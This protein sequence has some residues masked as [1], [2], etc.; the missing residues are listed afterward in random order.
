MTTI[1]R[2]LIGT[3]ALVMVLLAFAAY[4]HWSHTP[5]LVIGSKDPA[6]SIERAQPG[7]SP[8]EMGQVRPGHTEMAKFAVAD[9]VTK[10]LSRLFGFR[11]LLNPNEDTV[12]WRLEAPYMNL[13]EDRFFCRITADRGTVQ[14]E[15]VEGSYAPRDAEL[16]QNVRIYLKSLRPGDTTECLIYMNDLSYSSERSLFSTAGPVKVV[17]QQAELV[18]TGMELIYNAASARI[19]LLHIADL[20]SLR[21]RGVA[22]ETAA[23][24]GSSASLTETTKVGETQSL[25]P[26]DGHIA[27][28]DKPADA[29]TAS[30]DGQTS[31]S[32]DRYFCRLDKNIIIWYGR[33]LRVSGA[34]NVDITNILWARKPTTSTPSAQPADDGAATV[35]EQAATPQEAPR[36]PERPAEGLSEQTLTAEADRQFGPPETHDNDETDVRIT[37]DGGMLIR[38]ME[39]YEDETAMTP[40]RQTIQAFGSPVE[41]ARTEITGQTPGQAQTLA[42]C[43]MLRYDTDRSLLTIQRGAWNQDTVLGVGGAGGRLITSGKVTYDRTAQ[44]AIIAGGGRLEM[45]LSTRESSRE[46]KFEMVFDGRMDLFLA[47]ATGPDSPRELLLRR[48]DLTGGMNAELHSDGLARL[49]AENASFT[50]NAD[51]TLARADLSGDVQFASDEGLTVSRQAAIFFDGRNQPARADLHGAVQFSSASGTLTTEQAL[52]RF[53]AAQEGGATLDEIQTQGPATL[54]AEREPET[55]TRK[56]ARFRGRNLHYDVATGHAVAQGPIEFTFHVA[57]PDP[58]DPK[59]EPVPVVITATD[60]AEFDRDKNEFIFFGSVVGLHEVAQADYVQKSSFYGK[61]LIVRLAKATDSAASQAGS[62]IHSITLVGGNVKIESIRSR[63]AET[64]SHVRLRCVQVDYDA[65]KDVLVATGPGNVELNN[66]NVAPIPAEQRRK[67]VDLRGPC[68]GSIQGFAT[69]T[70]HLTSQRVIADSPDPAE[71]VQLA[72]QPIIEGGLGQRVWAAAPH[73]EVG[74]AQTNRGRSALNFFEARGNVFYCEEGGN[75]FLGS[76]SLRYNS[77]DDI[78]VVSCHPE[79]PCVLNGTP[80]AHIHYDLKT[81]RIESQLTGSPGVVPLVSQPDR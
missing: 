6:E 71:A 72:Y 57:P 40:P 33:R 49:T 78:M 51:S 45:P 10:K 44:Q 25:K 11:R 19:E 58:N 4:N 75:V 81:G 53:A 63:G 37:C 65:A 38:P 68:Y 64:I 20:D 24:A 74:F 56:P 21:V 76:D 16:S 39:Y 42:R 79:D 70:W 62:D 52:L 60:R 77:A 61:R 48:A 47:E 9:P 50:F 3:A 17:S 28:N 14:V 30:T 46:A 34:E 12:R 13:Y 8:L 67:P 36:V 69:V 54:S 35:S 55:A 27:P 59:A 80:V 7:P 32:S 41:V 18:G 26:S 31:P 22:G 1:R 43:G 29:D 23:T 5:E 73:L 15:K 2:I 66:E